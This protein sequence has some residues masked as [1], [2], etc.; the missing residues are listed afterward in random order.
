PD[1]PTLPEVPLT[2][3]PRAAAPAKSGPAKP[4][5][6]TNGARRPEAPV[7][8][9]S[10]ARDVIRTPPGSPAAPRA[11][12]SGTLG[13][14]FEAATPASVL[15]S[16]MSP[17]FSWFEMRHAAKTSREMLRL[18]KQVSARNPAL[19][20][21]PLYLEVVMARTG[22]DSAT[23]NELLEHAQDSFASWPAETELTF[24]DVVHYFAVSDFLASHVGSHWV[25][26]NMGRVVSSNV[27]H[28]L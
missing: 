6:S 1:L 13:L 3:V 24:R 5:P 23:A 20:G 9:R 4:R 25:R 17:L 7:R 14:Q 10:P 8:G 27:P 26:A 16:L 22:W 11:D 21:R 15:R 12:A 18:Y 28:D 19:S 2:P